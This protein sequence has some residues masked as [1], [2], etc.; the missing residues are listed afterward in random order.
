M[1]FTEQDAIDMRKAMSLLEQKEGQAAKAINDAKIT[2]ARTWFK[3]IL[4][5]W[6]NSQP[7]RTQ[8]NNLF[9]DREMLENLN[10]IDSFR[11]NII[12]KKINDITNNIKAV[13]VRL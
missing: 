10:E 12:R 4:L 1:V 6:N 2:T 9:A 3:I 11:N 7:P 8:L 5:T 13:K